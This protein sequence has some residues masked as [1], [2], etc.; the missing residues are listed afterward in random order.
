MAHKKAGGSTRLGR[1]SQSKRLGVKVFGDQFAKAGAIIVRQKGQK[2]C[3]GANVLQGT[4]F[5]LHALIEGKVQFGEEKL[6]RFTGALKKA[7][8][9]SVAPV[10]AK[11]VKK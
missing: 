10:E 8:I 1:D 2:F 6:T 9:V 3:A 5:T 7:R 4:D 11:K